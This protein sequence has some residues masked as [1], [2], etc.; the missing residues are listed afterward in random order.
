MP[1]VLL[2]EDDDNLRLLLSK[3]LKRHFNV[4]SAAD[5]MEALSVLEEKAADLLITDLA[6]PRMDGFQLAERVRERWPDMPILMLTANQS[7]SAKRTG[8]SLGTDDYLT[9]PFENEELIWRVRA[10]IRRAR[11]DEERKIEAGDLTIDLD[12]YTL[13]GKGATLSLPKKEFE[14]LCRLLSS[15]GRIFTRNQ[16]FEEIWGYESES[17]E[18]TVKTHISRLRNHLKD[19]ETITIT[20]VKGVGYKA[21][22]REN[23]A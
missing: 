3:R 11:I 17:G 5:G 1:T 15:P 21:E 19:M 16:L 20:A 2:A 23:E 7:F 4:L 14:L 9:K 18:D 8:F 22:V 12:S 13:T 10:L 6:M